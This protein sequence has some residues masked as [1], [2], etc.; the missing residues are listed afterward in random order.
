MDYIHIYSSHVTKNIQKKPT[1]NN[2][3]YAKVRFI[4]I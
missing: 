4:V 1:D 2:N 3:T